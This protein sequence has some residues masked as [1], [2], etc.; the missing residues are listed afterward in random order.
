MAFVGPLG[1]LLR[2]TYFLTLTTTSVVVHSGSGA[3]GQPTKLVQVIPRETVGE[4]ISDVKLGASWSS[5]RLR[6]PGSGRR[7]RLNVSHHSRTELDRFLSTVAR[8]G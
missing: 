2:K 5:F 8:K 3:G 1:V 4:L 6:F 7:V